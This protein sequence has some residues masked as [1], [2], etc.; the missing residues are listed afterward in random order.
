M[1][2]MNYQRERASSLLCNEE[3][4]SSQKSFSKRIFVSNQRFSNS[5]KHLTSLPWYKQRDKQ[6]QPLQEKSSKHDQ[7]W[8]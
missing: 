6:L 4:R 5:S 7:I 2:P 3:G 1:L 8:Y